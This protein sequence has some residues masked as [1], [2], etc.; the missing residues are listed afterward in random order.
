MFK[1]MRLSVK[2]I[3]GFIAVAAITTVIGLVGFFSLR[4]M[5]GHVGR[6]GNEQLPAVQSLLTISENLEKLKVAQRT[7]LSPTMA[8]ADRTRQYENVAK[9]REAYGKAITTYETLPHSDEEQQIWAKFK[10]GM[11]DW[12]K[13]NNTFFGLTQ[14]LEKADVLNPAGL[15][16]SIEK[17]VADHYALK[18]KV[19]A[20]V[21]RQKEFEGGEDPTAC[22]FGKWVAQFKT[23]NH[24]IGDAVKEMLD[25][26]KQFHAMVHQ[27]RELVKAGNAQEA[28]KVYDQMQVLLADTFKRFDRVRDEISKS[29]QLCQQISDQAF[30]GCAKKQREVEEAL[31]KII[32]INQESAA[33]AVL[34]ATS[35]SARSSTVMSIALVLG[36]ALAILLGVF[37]S[38]GITRPVNRMITALSEGAEQVTAASTQVAAASQSLAEGATEQAASLEETSSSLEQMSSQ[39][40]QNAGNAQQANGLASVA[41][42]AA[43]KGAESMGR[44]STAIK[45][46]QKSSDETAK[47][48]KVIDEIAFQT[49]LLALNAAVE[50]ARAGEAGKG[51][52]VVAEE[53]RNLAM[54]SAEAAKNTTRLIEESV[55]N[56]QSGVAI[57]GEVSTVLNEIVGSVGK[58]TDLVG[59]IAA[60]SQDQ[61]QG[62]DQINTAVGQMDKVTQQ[63]AANAEESASASEELSAQAE[64]MNGVIQELAVLVGGT[65]SRQQKAVHEGKK[66]SRPAASSQVWKKHEAL[67]RKK[68]PGLSPSDKVFH[69]I[70]GKSPKP[71]ATPAARDPEQV[72]PLNI[73]EDFSR[74]NG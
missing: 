45:D 26:H 35:E 8:T 44:M 54:R 25:P 59:E 6:V 15:G 7:L 24:V 66:V 5:K 56:S 52:A 12:K 4:S 27:T 10:L 61:S 60:A 18:D 70:A 55:K 63:N 43:Q 28:A 67:M 36:V 22:N 32:A 9:A 34:G 38:L 42:S 17:F 13:E 57:A 53:V 64:S 65:S 23:E 3:S 62:I 39:T 50:A 40:K 21:Q 73:D 47:I 1:G 31:D 16:M 46:I 74:L 68:G 72:I 29:S 14:E 69:R 33:K 49:N 30:G 48:I 51:F 37:L 2:L 20:M 11:E 58:T 19:A 71:A 41:K